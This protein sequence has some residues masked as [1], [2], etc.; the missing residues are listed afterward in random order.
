MGHTYLALRCL[1]QP[2]QPL[3]QLL[4]AQPLHHRPQLALHPSIACKTG[5]GRAGRAH[6]V[7]QSWAK[8]AP[9]ADTATVAV[10][11]MPHPQRKPHLTWHQRPGGAVCQ[12]C[13]Q[14][15][16]QAQQRCPPP[17]VRLAPLWRQAGSGVCILQGLGKAAGLQGS[18]RGGAADNEL[19]M[20]RKQTIQP[21]M[22]CK[23]C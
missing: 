7:S 8:S 10:K 4:A 15:A 2:Q 12:H 21:L 13:L 9:V 23:H 22:Q 3:A 14:R 11:C 20:P 5:Q 19:A 18:T 6:Q 1:Q 17:P 16:P